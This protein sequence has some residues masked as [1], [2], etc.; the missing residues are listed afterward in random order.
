MTGLI[1]AKMMH[2]PALK[3]H[4]KLFAGDERDSC[5]ASRTLTA[6]YKYNPSSY[7]Q[8]LNQQQNIFS[9]LA[10]NMEKKET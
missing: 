3:L 9:L 8:S 2:S 5:I 4:D 10:P 1:A 7:E 6:L